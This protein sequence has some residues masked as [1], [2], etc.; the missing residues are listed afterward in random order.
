MLQK[1]AFGKKYEI[2]AIILTTSITI[3]PDPI[4]NL[5][6]ISEMAPGSHLVGRYSS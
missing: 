6:V 5:N 2:K 1:V 3:Y 4:C